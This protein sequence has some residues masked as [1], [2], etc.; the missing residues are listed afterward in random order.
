MRGLDSSRTAA[1]LRFIAALSID[2][3]VAM[4]ADRLFTDM[5]ICNS[6]LGW[7]VQMD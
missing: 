3:G 7:R 2:I 5:L 6:D 4:S 1:V